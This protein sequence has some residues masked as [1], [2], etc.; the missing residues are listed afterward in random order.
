MSVL[1]VGHNSE[2]NWVAAGLTAFKLGSS[3]FNDENPESCKNLCSNTL[4][5]TYTIKNV[6]TKVLLLSIP[7]WCGFS[8]CS[9]LNF[10]I[11]GN[12]T[13]PR[14][15]QTSQLV[16]SAYFWSVAGTE[17]LK[18][19]LWLSMTFRCYNLFIWSIV[20]LYT[21]LLNIH[22]MLLLFNNLHYIYS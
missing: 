20:D 17:L 9:V 10:D 12:K 19:V 21:I 3:E 4:Y 6:H 11:S 18:Q 7:F 15:L 2:C 5:N 14:Y 22:V 13:I 16:E 8:N 1:G